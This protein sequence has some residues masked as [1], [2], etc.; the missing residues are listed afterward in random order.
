[1]LMHC[2]HRDGRSSCIL[3]EKDIRAIR[4]VFTQKWL[5]FEENDAD[6]ENILNL[7]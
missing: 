6:W 4:M 2:Q 1:M 5:R 7:K 3:E